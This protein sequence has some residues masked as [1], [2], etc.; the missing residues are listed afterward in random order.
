[1]APGPVLDQP[2]PRTGQ[3]TTSARDATRVF[4]HD[5]AR[6]RP[7]THPESADVVLLIVAELITNAIRH[8]DGPCTLHLELHDDH[9]EI[10]VTDTSPQPPQ[11]R[12]PHTDGTGGWGWQLISHLTTHT[13]TEPHPDGG[14]TICAHT[15]W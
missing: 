1:M 8:T 7:P 4:L 12:P 13:H 11:P 5:A 15:A 2:V 10:Q 6:M 14:K 9:I 3:P